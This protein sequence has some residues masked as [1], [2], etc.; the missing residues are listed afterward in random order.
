MD[1][2]LLKAFVTVAGL[3]NLTQSADLLAVSQPALTR[4]IQRLEEVLG[5][6]LFVRGRNGMELTAFGHQMLPEAQQALLHAE[7]LTRSAREY[8]EQ[9]ADTLRISFGYWAIDRVMATVEAFQ[10]LYPGVGME[11]TDMSSMRQLAGLNNA[12]L[13]IGFLRLRNNEGLN[14]HLLEHD[15]L[16]FVFNQRQSASLS[17]LQAAPLALLSDEIS[18][19]YRLQ[20]ERYFA[21]LQRPPNLVKV[22]N[23]FITVLAWVARGNAVT[24]IPRSMRGLMAGF[25]E[26]RAVPAGSSTWQLGLMCRH[27]PHRKALTEFVRLALDPA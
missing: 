9:V 15:E 16:I 26:L 3:E 2:Q 13:D 27:Q 22:L 21:D 11:L 23:E 19:D 24:L 5:G 8:R 25:P 14:A 20:V 4:Q 12:T 18:P 6:A 17:D 10:S 7:R 1:T